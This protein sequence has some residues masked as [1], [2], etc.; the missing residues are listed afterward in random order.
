MRWR[1]GL[2]PDPTEEITVLPRLPSWIKGREMEKKGR[3]GKRKKG[4]RKGRK[5]IRRGKEGRGR[6]GGK[7][8]T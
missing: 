5:E 4:D 6:E 3:E 1:P 7:G 2:A 8:K